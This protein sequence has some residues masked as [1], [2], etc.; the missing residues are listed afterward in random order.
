M[1]TLDRKTHR[2]CE[3]TLGDRWT[4]DAVLKAGVQQVV[5][6]RSRLRLGGYIARLENHF[7]RHVDRCVA[8]ST[9]MEG[10]RTA[11]LVC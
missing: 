5:W 3:K 6:L 11:V 8:T 10:S 2:S 7:A 4:E 1:A 9:N